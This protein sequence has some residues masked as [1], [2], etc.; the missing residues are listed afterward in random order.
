[1]SRPAADLKPRKTP[2][3]A[4]S[5]L[6]VEIIQT[7]CIQVL[8]DAGTE[9]FTTTRVA[10]RAGVSVGT[11]Y[12]YFPNKH[13]LLASVLEHHLLKVVESVEAACRG[14]K[15]QTTSVMAARVVEA[16]FGAKF[17]DPV[18]SRV[19]YAVAPEAGGSAVLARLA[20][21]A[22]LALC[23]MLATAS[24]RRFTELALTSLVLSTS[25]TGPV[26]A[27]LESP[28]PEKVVTQ[29]REHLVAMASAYLHQIG[30]R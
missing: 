30:V 16:F 13:A 28:V 2:V 8:V 3:Q 19:L 10:A 4:R 29:V 14:A 21:R 25:M 11:L 9:R 6:T 27:L 7:A 24:D 1:V 17:A 22:Q 23:D 26:Q 18:V 20:H 5:A 15:G 12:Q